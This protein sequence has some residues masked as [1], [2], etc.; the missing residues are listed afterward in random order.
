MV[1]QWR[2]LDEYSNR[3]AAGL[4]GLGLQP[5]DRIASLMPNCPSLVVHY[6]ACFKTGIV[7]PFGKFQIHQ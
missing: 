7:V 5:G 1:D 2:E 3:L 6:L 4:L